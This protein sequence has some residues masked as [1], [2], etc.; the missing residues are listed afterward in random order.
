MG[1]Y[2]VIRP[3]GQV[4][5]AIRSFLIG[6]YQILDLTGVFGPAEEADRASVM[7]LML[8]RAEDLS[9]LNPV[10]P[11]LAFNS[12]GLVAACARERP[13]ERFAAV[14]RPCE[15]R[16]LVEMNKLGSFELDK[17]VLI[18]VDCLGVFPHEDLDWRAGRAGGVEELTR[19]ALHFA[20]QGG[21]S[22]YRYRPACQICRYPMAEAADIRIGLLGSTERALMIELRTERFG[23]AAELG[24]LTDGPPSAEELARYQRRLKTALA[25]RDKTRFRRLNGLQEQAPGTIE[26]LLAMLEG[27]APCVACHQICPLFAELIRQ[28]VDQDP[29]AVLRQLAPVWLRSCSGCGVCEEYCPRNLPLA[30]IFGRLEQSLNADCGYRPGRSLTDAVPVMSSL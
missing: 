21:I 23:Q 7:P 18:G 9:R 5:P 25:R 11:W 13:R 28:S 10:L 19:Q 20:P 1:E 17:V 4:L 16:T 26:E 29:W 3:E 27:C 30:A 8:D 22:T 2:L 14:L 12:A 24:H 15:L 6:M